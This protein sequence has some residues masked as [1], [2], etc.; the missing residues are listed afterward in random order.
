MRAATWTSGATRRTDGAPT[1]RGGGGEPPRKPWT[2]LCPLTRDPHSPE[3]AKKAAAAVTLVYNLFNPE[4]ESE[5]SF[6]A[7]PE[8]LR[9]PHRFGVSFPYDGAYFLLQLCSRFAMQFP[10]AMLPD[11][12]HNA[13]RADLA[14]SEV[15]FRL[16]AR[17]ARMERGT[18]FEIPLP[19][20]EFVELRFFE[21]F[22]AYVAHFPVSWRRARLQNA[23]QD[24]DDRGRRRSRRKRGTAGLL[25]RSVQRLKVYSPYLSMLHRLLFEYLPRDENDD[26]EETAPAGRDREPVLMPVDSLD[27]RPSPDGML[28]LLTICEFWL[29]QYSPNLVEDIYV[30]GTPQAAEEADALEAAAAERLQLATTPRRSP[31][32]AR[33]LRSARSE[34]RPPSEELVH[35]VMILVTHMLD[36]QHIPADMRAVGTGAAAAARGGRWDEPH[37]ALD[38][39]LPGLQCNSVLQ[40]PLYNFFRLHISLCKV[41]VPNAIF[42]QLVDTWLAMLTPWRARDRYGADYV[43]PRRSRLRAITSTNAEEREQWGD[44]ASKRYKDYSR[45]EPFVVYHYSFYAG[46]LAA[47]TQRAVRLDFASSTTEPTELL[48][49]VLDVFESRIRK[50][51]ALCARIIREER[52]FLMGESRK[53]LA[54]PPRPDAKPIN[55]STRNRFLNLLSE[56]FRLVYGEGCVAKPFTEPEIVDNAASV[57]ASLRDAAERRRENRGRCCDRARTWCENLYGVELVASYLSRW[58]SSCWR[59][60]A[61]DVYDAALHG[62]TR[63]ERMLSVAKRLQKLFGVSRQQASKKRGKTGHRER[64]AKSFIGERDGHG[65]LSPHGRR[66]LAQGKSKSRALDVKFI[67]P[68]WR[69]PVGTHESRWLLW[70]IRHATE[71]FDAPLT[72]F[73]LNVA[74]HIVAV[75]QQVRQALWMPSAGTSVTFA[76]YVPGGHLHLEDSDGERAIAANPA[77]ARAMLRRRDRGASDSDVGSHSESGSEAFD[78]DDDGAAVPRSAPDARLAR[79]AARRMRRLELESHSSYSKNFRML[80]WIAD[81]RAFWAMV[82]VLYLLWRLLAWWFA[83]PQGT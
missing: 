66:Q 51:L 15:F 47:F 57:I 36:D 11:S 48:E 40:R 9:C 42:P 62:G 35:A 72:W 12:L 52:A 19:T 80:R 16:L 61:G 8:I 65:F 5:Q 20:A 23:L 68:E 64:T 59:V 73:R 31:L 32:G 83:A 24:D 46:L 78:T 43:E 69:R 33:Q 41:D 74:V 25:Y 81:W 27:R 53:P 82:L 2:E 71:R 21:I 63:R 14:R 13:V 30:D 28:L 56:H 60:L 7:T 29:Q 37:A 26:E 22:V 6:L 58:G 17:R 44:F 70:L 34:Y 4:P 45:W 39:G 67:G 3:N 76:D 77:A 10:I 50:T 18:P 55:E 1:A 75:R 79:K 38:G 54:P 49:R